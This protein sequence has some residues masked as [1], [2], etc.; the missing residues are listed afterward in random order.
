MMAA[1][2][3]AAAARR[4]WTL[5]EPVHVVTYFAPEARQ[6]FEEA[7]LRGFW[8]GYF[9]GRAAPIGAVDAPPVIA[10]FFSFAPPF[11]RRALPAVWGMVT[12]EQ[13]LVAR[14]AGAVAAIRRLVAE[15][16]GAAGHGAGGDGGDGRADGDSAGADGAAGALRAAADLLAAATEELA[17][18]GRPLGAP[19]A[20]L[21][22]PDE[23]VARLW[24]AA[25]VLREHRG[26]GHIGA[27]VAAGVDGCEALAL[28]VARGQAEGAG[29][30]R[31]QLQP[32]RGWTDEEWDAA[33]DRLASRGWLDAAGAITPA[34]R[35]AHQAIED[36]TD[37]AAARPWARLGT[38]R[39]E[40][41]A[42]LLTPTSLACAAVLPF[43][44]P[45]GLPRPA[46]P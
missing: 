18:A 43:P 27:L 42:R 34:G 25:T 46:T 3:T 24:H 36:A 14:T 26:D 5:F 6:G 1:M 20:A 22:A 31:A 8:R 35:A 2:E 13:A 45:V 16:D 15:G 39:T 44:N 41:L 33:A 12:P 32:A 29:P 40:E 28:R 11:V 23:P 7:G 21:P 17:M 4:M 19:N 30:S 10:A 37:V 38:E 9:A